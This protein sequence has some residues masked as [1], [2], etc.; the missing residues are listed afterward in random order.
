MEYILL[1]ITLFTHIVLF[2]DLFFIHRIILYVTFQFYLKYSLDLLDKIYLTA[3]NSCIVFHRQ[4][5][6]MYRT[7]SKLMVI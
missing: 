6:E 2:L 4:D 1:T 5:I 3:F 7:I